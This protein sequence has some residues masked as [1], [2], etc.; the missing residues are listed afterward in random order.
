[1]RFDSLWIE[2][3]LAVVC[4][5]AAFLLWNRADAAEDNAATTAQ[6]MGSGDPVQGKRMIKSENCQEC[7]GE[8]GVGLA[9]SAPKL[10]GQ[11]SDYIVKQLRNF[12]SGERKH[13]VMTVMAEA[14]TDD[15]RHDIAAHYSGSPVMQ[16]DGVEENKIARELYFR[17]DMT[18]NIMPC[19]SCHGETGKGKYSETECYPVIGGQHMIYLREQL[20]NWR[21]GERANSPGGVMNVIA[22]SLSDT[23]IQAL[24]DFI[25]GF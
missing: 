21:K 12:Q 24:A 11:Y 9:P 4:V 10:A 3:L 1:M 25:S 7:H 20:R 5:V 2:R 15:D 23:E 18:R 6:R 8:F 13:P 17:G 22:K 14:L 19:K 16:G